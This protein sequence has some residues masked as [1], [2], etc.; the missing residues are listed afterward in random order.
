MVATVPPVRIA[1]YALL[2]VPHF[3]PGNVPRP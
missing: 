3:F 2:L 1:L